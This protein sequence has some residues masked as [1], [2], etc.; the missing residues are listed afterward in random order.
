[1]K[2]AFK[3]LKELLENLPILTRPMVYV[4]RQL[5]NKWFESHFIIIKFQDEKDLWN[6]LNNGTIKI[7]DNKI[8]VFR[9]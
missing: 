7:D 2:Q 3:E 5:F 9:G 4:V 1:M 6:K 8:V